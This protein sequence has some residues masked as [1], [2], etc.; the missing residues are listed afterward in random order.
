MKFLNS[1]FNGLNLYDVLWSC[2]VA[3]F[4]VLLAFLGKTVDSWMV[5]PETFPKVD[6]VG[7]WLSLKIAG[8]TFCSTL[9]VLFKTN[10]QGQLLKKEN[11]ETL[12][13]LEVMEKAQGKKDLKS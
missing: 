8:A 4:T 5:N 1:K 6:M 12:K 3:A 2:V 7:L 10:S 13:A 11:I 9:L